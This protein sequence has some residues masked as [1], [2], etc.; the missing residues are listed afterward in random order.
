MTAKKP[1]KRAANKPAHGTRP[2]FEPGNE[3]S[4]RH[5]AYSPA[6]LAERAEVVH[7]SLLAYAPW[8]AEPHYAPSVSRYL[9]ATAREQLAH[10][11][12]IG[13]EPGA[14][15]FTRLL[16]TAT[17]ASR[18]AW[19]YADQLG[20]TPTGHAKLKILVAGGEHAEASLADLAAEGQ[21][22]RSATPKEGT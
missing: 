9:E 21:R 7:A 11:A 18:L 16:E 20:L 10:Q 15:G 17:A 14:K 1:A 2:P 6:K 13:M 12:L 8:V 22:T 4:L 19:L 5:G 3:L